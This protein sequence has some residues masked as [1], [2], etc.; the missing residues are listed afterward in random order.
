ATNGNDAKAS[1]N[2]A[3]NVPTYVVQSLAMAKNF[4]ARLPFEMRAEIFMKLDRFSLD[5]SG[6]ACPQ[7]RAVV[8]CLFGGSLRVLG[9]ICLEATKSLPEG[10]DPYMCPPAKRK[11][12]SPQH[13]GTSLE[14]KDPAAG[15]V[16]DFRVS[17]N[18][19]SDPMALKNGSTDEN[20]SR[21]WSFTD[22]DAASSHFIGLLRHASVTEVSLSGP[23][24]IRLLQGLASADVD[25]TIGGLYISEFTLKSGDLPLARVALTSFNSLHRLAIGGDVPLDLITNDFLVALKSVGVIGFEFRSKDFKLPAKGGWATGPRVLRNNYE[26]D[27]PNLDAGLMSFLFRGNESDKPVYLEIPAARVPQDFCRQLL[28]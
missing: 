7:F 24:P 27:Y 18:Y 28:K 15:D 4:I 1:L 2:D 22:A 12:L 6:F 10:W 5:R 20:V 8:S 11:R 21:G 25:V 23:L 13:A 9:R 3:Q 16:Y 17:V 26:G 14:C 19:S